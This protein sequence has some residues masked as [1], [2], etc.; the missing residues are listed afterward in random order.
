MKNGLDQ[1]DLI[2]LCQNSER[3]FA[4]L[5]ETEKDMIGAFLSSSFLPWARAQWLELQEPCGD[6]EA[7]KKR[8]KMS[9]KNI[10]NDIAKSLNKYQ[11]LLNC[12]LLATRGKINPY[13]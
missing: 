5:D 4:S 2:D 7:A 9:L 6:P 12:R 10:S 3:D 1:W 11:Q 13:V 8:E